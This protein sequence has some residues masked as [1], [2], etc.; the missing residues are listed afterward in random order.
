[1]NDKAGDYRFSTGQCDVNDK[2]SLDRF[3][4][5]RREWLDHLSRDEHHSIQI[6]LSS[7]AWRDV[8]YRL[9]G[10]IAN[11]DAASGLRNPLVAEALIDGYFSVQVLAIR[12]LMGRA[13]GTI[14]LWR[15]IEDVRQSRNLFTRE[16]FVAFDG[17]PYDCDQARE[18]V[19]PAVIRAGA[20]WA[21]REG[22]DA[23]V[24]AQ[25]AHDL[26]DKLSGIQ[27]SARRRDDRI[28]NRIFDRIAQWRDEADAD[29]L[30][31]W[32]NN[33]LAHAA[34][35]QRR[36][37]IDV[38]A[39][40]P[41]T[42]KVTAIIRSCIRASEGVA[43]LIRAAGHGSIVPVAQFNQLERLNAPL[44]VAVF[45]PTLRERWHLLADERDKFL[46]G[47]METLVE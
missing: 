35:R 12:R 14:S 31:K 8:A 47:V 42:D 34:G 26:F 46:D 24:P 2:L 18:R 7:M 9:L 15:L 11:G 37:G 19:M 23:W 29:S 32:C 28:P 1:M 27:P 33:F 43:Y 21:A 13:V 5:K 22:P 30:L 25:M 44:S 4:Q 17:L 3:R 40:G 36:D 41:N 39:V 38:R 16:N 6:L 45:V 10:D 20:A